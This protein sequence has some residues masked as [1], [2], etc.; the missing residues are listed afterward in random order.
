MKWN[1][2]KRFSTALGFSV[3]QYGSVIH[4]TNG[5]ENLIEKELGNLGIYSHA[6]ITCMH[7]IS[8]K[9]SPKIKP[10]EMFSV[11]NIYSTIYHF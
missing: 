8:N 11:R 5:E 7:T 1:K 2:C 10:S 3:W 4:M 9:K 6:Y